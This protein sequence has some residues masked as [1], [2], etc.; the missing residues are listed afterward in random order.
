MVAAEEIEVAALA[1][2]VPVIDIKVSLA[3]KCSAKCR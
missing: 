2:L 1:D 3:E